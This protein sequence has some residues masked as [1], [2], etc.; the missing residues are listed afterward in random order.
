M[1]TTFRC[2]L[3][4]P[5]VYKNQYFD[6]QEELD[7][8]IALHGL[9]TLGKLRR[10]EHDFVNTGKDFYCKMC[11]F[12]N[13]ERTRMLTYALAIQHLNM[14]EQI[15][16]E[17]KFLH[18]IMITTFM[19]DIYGSK[20]N[21][22]CCEKINYMIAQTTNYERCHAKK[23]MF[24]SASEFFQHFMSVHLRTPPKIVHQS[25]KFMNAKIKAKQCSFCGNTFCKNSYDEDFDELD[26]P[27]TWWPNH[28]DIY[29]CDRKYRVILSKITKEITSRKAVLAFL[30][31]HKV[32][33]D[34][35]KK[36][37]Q[38]CLQL[39]DNHIAKTIVSFMM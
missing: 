18:E 20:I 23:T 7:D 17:S 28:M 5:K 4:L 35:N 29:H 34:P 11:Y 21:C 37:V 16:K 8:H 15:K 38:S 22:L 12:N 26:L 31:C 33:N 2:H 1:E 27:S 9:L 36:N 3:C 25:W 39:I 6:S 24:D 13:P 14:H 19:F 32:A 30:F 10:S